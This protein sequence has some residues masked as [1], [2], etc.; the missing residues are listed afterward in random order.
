MGEGVGVGVGV[1]RGGCGETYSRRRGWRLFGNAF[2]RSPSPRSCPRLS[3]RSRASCRSAHRARMREC[4]SRMRRRHSA[5][6]FPD[7]CGR[8]CRL[9]V[10]G[11]VF[12]TASHIMD[13][14]SVKCV[15]APSEYAFAARAMRVCICCPRHASMH[16]LPAPCEYAFAARAIRICI[17][18]PRHANVHL[19]PAPCEYALRGQPAMHDFV[20]RGQQ[21]VRAPF[22]PFLYAV[23]YA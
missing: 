8:V 23:P 11:V 12:A 5:Y 21:C 3:G 10:A 4:V 14:A 7:L 17:C 15:P 16:L 6:A 13:R 1:G 19:L 22:L 9:W 18:C 20:P 2:P